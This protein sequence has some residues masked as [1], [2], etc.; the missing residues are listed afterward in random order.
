MV[1][2]E[3]ST[4]YKF[5]AKLSMCLLAIVLSSFIFS[6][7]FTKPVSALCDYNGWLTISFATQEEIDQIRQERNQAQADADEAQ[8]IVDALNGQADE[9]SGELSELNELS[10]EQRA[11][12]DEISEQYAAALL[13]KA[14]ALDRYVDS[15]DNLANQQEIFSN[16]IS[17]MFEY[18]NK[19]TLEVLLDS[20]NIAGFF[21]N[22]E[23]ITLIAD[24]D[25]QAVD[26]MQ[27]ALDDAQAQA[28]Y[29]LQEAEDMQAIA[30]EKQQQLQELED[31][32]GVTTAA[33]DDVNTQISNAE[34][35]EDALEAYAESLDSQ[36]Y[37]LQQEQAASATRAA[38]ATATTTT[39]SSGTSSG[40]SSSGTGTSGGGSML[41][42]TSGGYISSYYGWRTHPV[43][44]TQKFH[45]GIDIAV[46]FGT[47]V[48]AADS[49]TV[50]Y[51]E[52]PCLGCN[53]GG[54]GYG[55]YVIIDHGNGISTLYGHMR[56]VYV[57]NGETVSAGQQIG[58]VGSTGTSTGAH[59]HFEVRVNGSTVD[60]TGYV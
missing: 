15:Q 46:G 47:P 53:Y 29:A 21:T 45:S 12:Y 49:G 43:Y 5:L 10:A 1:I 28:E 40:S 36:I 3:K 23:L 18:Q 26:Q 20:D 48:V 16:R 34:A 52:T 59:L 4:G 55:N 60:P 27:I 32:I 2:F 39:G 14:D 54:S 9:L 50:I 6:G 37:Q 42:P 11:Q 38:Q 31:R 33:L 7:T 58:E 56:N 24:A 25:S 57:S 51:L 44:G 17:V 8:A 13:A 30:E 35:Q 41:W 19:S 22:M